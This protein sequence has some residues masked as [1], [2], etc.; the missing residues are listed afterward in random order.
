MKT[1]LNG[2]STTTDGNE[3]F[4]KFSN[5]GK[6]FYHKQEQEAVVAKKETTEQPAKPDQ[7]P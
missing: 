5:R 2:C 1:D 4:E 3:H 7:N 6:T